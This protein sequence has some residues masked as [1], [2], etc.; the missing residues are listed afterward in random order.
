MKLARI[1]QRPWVWHT[2][3]GAALFASVVS[4]V[5]REGLAVTWALFTIAILSHDIGLLWRDL[6]K[7]REAEPTGGTDPLPCP[8]CGAAPVL[9]WLERAQAYRVGCESIRCGGG[10]AARAQFPSQARQMWDEG[11]RDMQEAA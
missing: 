5:A 7:A 2:L 9:R 8:S 1:D 6:N 3:A 11:V 10:F 4:A